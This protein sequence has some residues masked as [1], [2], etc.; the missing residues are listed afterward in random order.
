MRGRAAASVVSSHV[1]GL[2]AQLV[3]AASG[4]TFRRWAEC[5]Y[6]PI[7]RAAIAPRAP[8]DRPRRRA[9]LG[10]RSCSWAVLPLLR[11]DTPAR[12]LVFARPGGP[13]WGSA[14]G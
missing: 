3:L 13:E 12:R 9:L 11:Y 5:G 2:L 1:P 8:G 14:G 6:L 10:R 7:V 4:A